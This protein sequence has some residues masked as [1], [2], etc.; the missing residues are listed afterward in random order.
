MKPQG[1]NLQNSHF[2][3]NLPFMHGLGACK[4][5]WIYI[6]LKI[7]SLVSAP[8]YPYFL[9]LLLSAAWVRGRYHEGCSEVFSFNW[10]IHSWGRTEL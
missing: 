2:E 1:A 9:L 7:R 5:H 3:N 10:H 8:S 4:S 6:T